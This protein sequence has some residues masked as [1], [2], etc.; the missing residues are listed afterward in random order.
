MCER[1]HVG[2]C[3]CGCVNM[4]MYVHVGVCMCGCVNMYMYVSVCAYACEF[5]PL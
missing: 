2:V 1:A 5:Q 4:Y 3:M